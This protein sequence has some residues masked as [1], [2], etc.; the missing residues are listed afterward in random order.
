MELTDLAGHFSGVQMNGRGFRARCPAHGSSG[1]SLQI[2]RGEK[3]WLV[4]CYAG[5]SFDEVAA[6]AELPRSAFMYDSNQS[7]SSVSA[8]AGLD[9]RRKLRSLILEKR[10]IKHRLG[11]IAEVALRLP[12]EMIV[13][14]AS[15]Y[16]TYVALPLP[17][18]LRMF[19]VVMDTV[20]W[21]MI[22]G[23]WDRYG[24]NWHE[25]KEK[26]Q[27]LLWEAYRSERGELA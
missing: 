8:N 5:C 3:G 22:G 18:A 16:P 20:V 26:I 11:E 7:S 25:A 6:A 14:M 4:R 27:M 2:L 23:E 17:D 13:R 15:R 9:A 19:S 24:R 1:D 12:P 10:T 21:D